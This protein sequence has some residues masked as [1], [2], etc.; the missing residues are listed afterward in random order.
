M[1][2]CLMVIRVGPV[3]IFLRPWR[4]SC[5]NLSEKR[6]GPSQ[7]YLV[8]PEFPVC[9]VLYRWGWGALG[10]LLQESSRVPP[11]AYTPRCPPRATLEHPCIP[12]VALV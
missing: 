3:V 12:V 7:G 8:V 10:I 1:T 5:E 6:A 4:A 11:A 2:K 9:P